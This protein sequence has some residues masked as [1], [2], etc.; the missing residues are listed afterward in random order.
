[1]L[2]NE[3]LEALKDDFNAATRN[4]NIRVAVTFYSKGSELV[5]DYTGAATE[6]GNVTGSVYGL[7]V[8]P[9]RTEDEKKNPDVSATVL[10][11]ADD[12]EDLSITPKQ[13]DRVLIDGDLLY[14]DSIS[15]PIPGIHYRLTAKA[16]GN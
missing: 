7:K 13:E 1:M 4:P 5:N 14:I 11:A 8:N 2:S 15:K 9:Q 16:K 3:Q 10:I 6:T 12:L